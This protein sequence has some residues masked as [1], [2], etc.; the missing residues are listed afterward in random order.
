MYYSTKRQQ[1]LIDQGYAFKVVTDLPH[2]D[3]PTIF[4]TKAEEQ[5]ELLTKI[6]AVDDKEGAE[7]ELAVD[8]DSLE[9]NKA[10]GKPNVKRTSG[11]ASSLSGGAGM[12]YMEY[13]T[14]GGS[15]N[16]FG[17]PSVKHPMFKNKIR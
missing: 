17:R 9:M 3:D 16:I 6:L 13:R 15:K 14:G 12:M 4:Y 1:Y 5:M 8:A 10:L 7:E 11:S 2:K